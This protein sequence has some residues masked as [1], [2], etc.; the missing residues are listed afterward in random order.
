M[1]I[2][3]TTKQTYRAVKCLPCLLFLHI[4]LLTGICAQTTVSVKRGMHLSSAL[5]QEQQDTC[6][7]LTVEG[8]L[9]S[10]D[11]MVLR[12]MAGDASKGRCGKLAVLDLSKARFTKDDVPFMTLD[13]SESQLAGTALPHRYI[14]NS[15]S[16]PSELRNA[17][18]S[19]IF[20]YKP[21]YLLGYTR[22]EPVTERTMPEGYEYSTL[23]TLPKELKESGGDFRFAHGMTDALWREMNE[24][25]RVTSFKGHRIVREGEQIPAAC[26]PAQEHLHGRHVLRM[27][28]SAGA[29]TLDQDEDRLQRD[30]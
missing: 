5:T 20:L 9:N 14:E 26:L 7:T 11:I 30:G 29:D 28:Q 23:Y 21:K 22:K 24:E 12:Q 15:S 1:R 16:A 3:V 17:N 6:T 18:D 27:P 10:A 13:A 4:C 25:F 8:K 2:M 19:P